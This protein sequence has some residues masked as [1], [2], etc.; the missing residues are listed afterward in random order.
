MTHEPEDGPGPVER[1]PAPDKLS[2][3]VVESGD[4]PRIHGY[5]VGDDLAPNYSFAEIVLLSLGGALPEAG[6]GRAFEIALAFAAPVSIAEAPANAAGLARLCGA[7]SKSV[8]SVGAV[9]LAEQAASRVEAL[10]ELVAWLEGENPTFPPCAVAPPSP[11]VTALRRALPPSFAALEIFDRSPSL[12]AAIVAVLCACGLRRVDR[13]IAALTI[14]GLGC[15][16]AEAFA[17]KALNLRGYPMD[18]P[19][20]EYVEEP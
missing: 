4:A 20:F 9:V 3:R 6:A 19:P 7:A 10:R 12:D 1:I 8:V 16:C 17:V 5:A 2:A 11:V 13:M 14:A 15:T 18:L